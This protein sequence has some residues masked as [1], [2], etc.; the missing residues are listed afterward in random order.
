MGVKLSEDPCSSLHKGWAGL[1]GM[2]IIYYKENHCQRTARSSI[3]ESS[4][5]YMTQDSFEAFLVLTGANYW[6]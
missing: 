3:F 4:S 6:E 5:L 1:D 2:K